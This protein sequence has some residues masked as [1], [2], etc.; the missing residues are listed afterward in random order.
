[1]THAAWACL[2]IFLTS[3]TLFFL[4]P[5]HK[6]I[7][8]MAAST[9]I[10]LTGLLSPLDVLKAP[11]YNVLMIFG[12]TLLVADLFMESRV[13]DIMASWIASRSS[14]AALAMVALCGLSGFLSVALENVATV[15]LIAPI[16]FV[17]AKRCNV[18]PVP[19]LIGV[20]ISSNLQGAATLIG[21]PPSILLASHT[22]MTFNDFF[23]DRGR[24]SMFFA[25]Q[26]AAAV[27]LVVLWYA[28]R[29]LRQPMPEFETRPILTMVPTWSLAG[30]VLSLA[31]VSGLR[32]G[33]HLA[34]GLAC[35]VWAV[36]CMVWTYSART[37]PVVRVLRRYDWKTTLFLVAVFVLVA[38]LVETGVVDALAAWGGRTI[39]GSPGLAFVAVVALSVG[40]SAFVDN[41]PYV[42]AMLPVVG[43]IAAAMGLNDP[44][45]FY[46][47]LLIGASVGGNITPIGAS[48][49]IVAVGTL[50][51]RGYDVSFRTFVS[52][53]LPYT[54]ITVA[55]ASAFIWLVFAPGQ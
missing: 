15:L 13:P 36:I 12:G 2:A 31:V 52:M 21:D 10:A 25:V 37:L 42:A 46:F 7:T 49:N 44:T 43:Q 23:F 41:V 3:Y 54:L 35:V 5:R 14:S 50:H 32:V 20:S 8:G 34:L 38:S 18:S 1:M 22:G 40:F 17:I 48:A 39:G 19:L 45:V 26:L 6:W 33:G 28:L 53:G 11:D 4:L 24:P 29:R 30:M 27:G 55:T 47:G 9:L 51:Q 16:C